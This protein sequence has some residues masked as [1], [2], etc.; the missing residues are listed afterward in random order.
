MLN[1]ISS[2]ANI[3]KNV[4]IG[5]FT[6]IH[7]NVTIGDNTVIEDHCIIGYPTK[8]AGKKS[9]FIGENSHIRS[10]SIFYEGSTL[11]NNLVT[12]HS[13]LVRENTEAGKYL[14]IGS[15]SDIEGECIIGNYVKMHTGV[16]VGKKAK[17][18]NLVWLFPRVQF[19][20][21][22][23]PPSKYLESV[24]INDL[25]VIATSSILLPGISVGIGSFV[26]A[27]SIVKN[28]VP[29]VMCVAGNPAKI[30]ARI[31]QLRS[32]KYPIK[33]PWPTYFRQGYPEESFPLMDLLVDK[34]E[35][36]IQKI[37][38]NKVDKII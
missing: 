32:F 9:L 27:G 6:I 29:D 19:T 3:G 13:V 26:A 34:I 38:L 14:Q 11:G 8:L 18:G 5:Y 30:V 36:L 4:K 10:H 23:F 17:I 20:N 37:K 2:K 22:P 24:T 25:A 33:Y 1:R 12:G 21:D 28:D 31:D 35:S 16:Q 15:Y 7:D